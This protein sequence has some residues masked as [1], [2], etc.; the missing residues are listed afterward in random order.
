MKSRSKKA[1]RN[2]IWL[3]TLEVVTA[4]C[5]LILP[6][7]ILSYFGSTYN[8]ITQSIAYFLSCIA[9][10]KSG[11]GS[12]TRAAL[13][14]PLAQNDSV[15]ISKVVNATE[16]FMRRIALIFSIFVLFFA[17]SYPFL[18]S[19]D[20]SWIF[21]F[22]LVLILSASTVAQYYF[23]ITYQMLIQADQNDYIISI[24]SIVSTIIS[25]VIAS[26]M[27]LSG[28]TIHMVK[29]GSAVVFVLPPIFY[30]LYSR[31]KYRIDKKIPADASL[32]SQRWDAFA[33]QISNF[34]NDN[35]AVMLATVFLGVKEVSVYAIYNM[36]A[37]NM[38]KVVNSFLSGTTAAFGNM[39]IKE[40][41]ENLR[42]RFDQFELL[43]FGV[44]TVLFTTTAILYQ[45]FIN[46][47]TRGVTDA[48]YNRP[49]LGILF[50]VACFFA[51][52]KLIYENVIFAAGKFKETKKFAYWEAII[53]IG[54]S[55]AFVSSFGLI[56]ILTGAIVAG[57]FRTVTYS[58]FASGKVVNRTPFQP[59]VKCVYTCACA[60]S[61]LLLTRFLPISSVADYLTWGLNAV[62]VFF[63]TSSISI[64][65][66]F[67]MFRE[68]SMA[69]V[70]TLFSRL[71]KKA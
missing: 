58:F 1:I 40:E 15:G 70:K 41:K 54:V 30:N 48:D 9:I 26:I 35:T 33:H 22:T 23:G 25:T 44:C 45:P 7:L 39:I 31:E 53:N 67:V 29:L 42:R 66:A 46:I 57:V 14:K 49:V 51:C 59:F 5:G 63:I 27:I 60:V 43:I 24:V 11:I 69:I 20:F 32:I 28:C 50:C 2:T 4:V 38:R 65:V 21:A 56:G 8:G 55:I 10:L 61:A 19:D 62:G 36:V 52:V 37:N 47:Y 68:D 64:A 18:V 16:S 12:V 71:N 34:I 3:L 17:A 6:R 13:Y